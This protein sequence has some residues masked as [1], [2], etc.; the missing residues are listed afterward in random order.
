MALH[1]GC[2]GSAFKPGDRFG[3]EARRGLSV[4][5]RRRDDSWLPPGSRTRAPPRREAT[6]VRDCEPRPP[7]AGSVL[8]ESTLR[9]LLQQQGGGVE[10][11]LSSEPVV[12]EDV[13]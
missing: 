4:L 2:E 8:V 11:I 5:L 12:P 6:D 7:Y 10:V 1:L 13:E 9:L 3:S